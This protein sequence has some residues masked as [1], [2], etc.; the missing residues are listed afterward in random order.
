MYKK[1]SLLFVAMVAATMVSNAQIWI[2]GGIGF[3]STGG[4]RNV[5]GNKT[6]LASE[7][8][9]TFAPKVGYNL[10]DIFSVG[11]GFGLTTSLTEGVPFGT[12]VVKD[13]DSSTQ[14]NLDLFARYTAF[15]AGNLSL[16]LQGGFGLGGRNEEHKPAGPSTETKDEYAFFNVMVLPVVQYSLSDKFSLEASFNFLGFGFHTETHTSPSNVETTRY[17]IGLNANKSSNTVNIRTLET[18][19]LLTIGLIFKL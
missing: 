13:E 3:S 9:F 14:W 10:N 7:T 1:V 19:P 4:E 2:G 5:G 12:P 15:E 17:N 11:L 8:T 16:L 6:D 18:G